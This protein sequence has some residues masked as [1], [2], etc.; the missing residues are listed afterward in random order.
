MLIKICG[1][2]NIDDILYC[3]AAGADMLGI[4]LWSGSPRSVNMNTAHNILSILRESTSKVPKI[5]LLFV[6]PQEDFLNEAIESL[7]PDALQIHGNWDE[8]EYVK[9]VPVIRAFSIADSDDVVRVNESSYEL[10]LID[11][12]VDGMYG[13][14]GRRIPEELLKRITKR[15]L[16]AGGLTPENVAEVIRKF[17]PYGVD[18]ATGVEKA[19]GK[20]DYE[21]VSS[22]IKAVRGI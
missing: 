13:G 20:K 1:I 18:T 17:K 12:K 8:R 19:P 4:N 2:T 14:T 9:G 6:E 10:V 22:F 16:L 3:S 7:K 15:Y 21:K 5:V 11:A